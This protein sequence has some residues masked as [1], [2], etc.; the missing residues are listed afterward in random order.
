[1]DEKQPEI[2]RGLCR[3]FGWET[4]GVLKKS[5]YIVPDMVAN[6]ENTVRKWRAVKNAIR[7]AQ[8]FRGA[9]VVVSKNAS[10]YGNVLRNY[11]R[12]LNNY[13]N[14]ISTNHVAHGYFQAHPNSRQHIT[15]AYNKLSAL[16]NQLN[17]VAHK[18]VMVRKLQKTR[19]AAVAARN[20]REKN[21]KML[22]TFLAVRNL[23]KN[24]ANRE[25]LRQVY[26]NLHKSK[27]PFGP[28]TEVNA[29]RKMYSRKYNTY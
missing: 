15:A 22:S 8:G 10:A 21:T 16:N 4:A 28:N 27:T 1:M 24:M 19:R 5:Q 3:V 18:I 11:E 9:S 7:R 2:D 20:K 6:L 12:A 13:G 14:D 26:H 23:P 25:I 17:K 29:L